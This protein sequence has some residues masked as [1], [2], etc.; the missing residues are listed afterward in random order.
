VETDVF[1]SAMEKWADFMIMLIG[2][3]ERCVRDGKLKELGSREPDQFWA[4]A[5]VRA[6]FAAVEGFSHG[7]KAIAVE[8]HQAGGLSLTPEEYSFLTAPETHLADNGQVK[9][10]GR[11]TK[12]RPNLLYALDLLTRIGGGKRGGNRGVDGFKAVG[13]GLRVRDG[14]THPKTRKD[15]HITWAEVE[16]VRE[17]AQWLG[18]ELRRVAS[19]LRKRYVVSDSGAAGP[20]ATSRS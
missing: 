18:E 19:D 12:T 20:V 16:L 11:H 7:A 8:A 6:F 15:L 10:R 17:A 13:Q 3:T 1:T 5:L 14:I 2:D 9:A 4:R